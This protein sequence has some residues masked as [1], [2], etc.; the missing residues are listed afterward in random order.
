LKKLRDYSIG[1]KGLKDGS[2]DFDYSINNAFFSLF[3]DALY[4]DGDVKARVKLSKGQQML[5][6]EF[7]L[8]GTVASFCDNCL[9]GVDVSIDCDARLYVKFGD[10]YD[11]PGDDIIVIPREEHE[12]NIAQHIYDLI[13][14]SLPIRHLH[15]MEKNGNRACNPEMV[16]KLGEYLVDQN[17][18]VT[19]DSDEDE[20]DPRWNELKK[21]MNK[22][23]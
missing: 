10:D 23:K 14:T 21:L 18:G 3:E 17:I 12:I 15:P 4:D 6:L 5:I 8:S 7:D 16:S 20:V 9:E 19:V 11:E 22:N 13:V 2:H 1:F